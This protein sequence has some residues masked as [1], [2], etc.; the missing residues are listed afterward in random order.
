[1][2]LEY[3]SQAIQCNQEFLTKTRSSADMRIA[4]AV[5]PFGARA[6]LERI[7]TENPGSYM[8]VAPLGTKPHSL[9]A[10][11]FTLDHPDSTEIIFD[12]PIPKRGGT[13]G[14]GSIHVYRVQ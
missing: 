14:I 13:S 10:F 6:E 12:H 4:D 9:G 7:A 8:Y 2:H 1:M 3:P 11:L 5:C